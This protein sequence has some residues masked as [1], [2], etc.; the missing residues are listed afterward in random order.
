MFS[1]EIFKHL[2][3][4]STTDVE[5]MSSSVDA[6]EGSDD[7]EVNQVIS[8][9]ICKQVCEKAKWNVLEESQINTVY[10]KHPEEE[11]PTSGIITKIHAFD[12]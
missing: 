5:Q 8:K 10:S 1:D 12:I 4:E 2:E 11:G 9:D 6:I 3:S 7:L